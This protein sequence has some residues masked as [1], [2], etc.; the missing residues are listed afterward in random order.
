[1]KKLKAMNRHN[2]F[3]SHNRGETTGQNQI[4]VQSFS[5][6]E[7]GLLLRDF[8]LVAVVRWNAISALARDRNFLAAM[9]PPDAEKRSTNVYQLCY[10]TK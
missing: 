7:P 6:A 8:D 4:F 10:H 1:M 9:H 2:K 3:R 5:Q